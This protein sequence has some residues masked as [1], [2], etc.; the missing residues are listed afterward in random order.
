MEVKSEYLKEFDTMAI[1]YFSF[2]QVVALTL[3]SNASEIKT[4]NTEILWNN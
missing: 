3:W 4:N 2:C 1:K